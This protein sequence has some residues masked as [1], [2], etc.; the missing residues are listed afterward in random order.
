M[1][2]KDRISDLIKNEALKS[3]F[4]ACGIAQARQLKEIKP[5]F[6]EWLAGGCHGDMH[7]MERHF[8]KRLDPRLLLEKAQ[9]II[10]LL[11]AYYPPIL[12]NEKGPVIS[13]YA[14]GKD[15]H[16]VLKEKMR[17]LAAF[18]TKLLPNAGLRIFTDSAPVA[19]KKWAQLAGLGW[20]GKNTNLLTR[21]GSF[22]FISEIL[23]D[24]PLEYDKPYTQDHCGNC[25]RC[26]E[27]CPTNALTPYRLDARKCISYQTIENKEAIPKAFENQFENRVFGCD[28]CQ[29]VCPF[30][31][32]PIITDEPDFFASDALQKMTADDWQK[33]ETSDFNKLFKHSAVKRSKYGGFMRNLRFINFG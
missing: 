1:E 24:A 20:Q 15:Y 17:K 12:L 19:E 27:A 33:L 13:K 26:I 11:H 4:Y 5:A 2:T 18:I 21:K 30:N 14:Y 32:K 31:R 16:F 3:G 6:S 22:F 28:I 9:S 7:Y 10:V 29:D 8:D 25:T 23:I